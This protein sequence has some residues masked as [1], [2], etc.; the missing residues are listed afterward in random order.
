MNYNDWLESVPE[1]I[2][3]DAVWRMQVYQQALFMGELAW[4][5]VT[6]LMQ[7][8]RTLRLA[9]QLYRSVGS[10]SAN[11]AEGYSRSSLK[12][13]ARFYDGPWF[14]S[15]NLGLVLQRPKHPGL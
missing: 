5:D 2:T 12:D 7:D 11:I 14:C 10:I 4:F 9:D 13:Q 8:R 15:R 1:S 3:N 6:K